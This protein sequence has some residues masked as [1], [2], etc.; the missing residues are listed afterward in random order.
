M[1]SQAQAQG[2]GGNR[3]YQQ[4]HGTKKG[5]KPEKRTWPN[6]R[7]RAWQ[8]WNFKPRKSPLISVFLNTLLPAASIVT[9]EFLPEG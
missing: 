6:H 4:S 2:S 8:R 9:N 3:Y 7:P 5:L 1:G